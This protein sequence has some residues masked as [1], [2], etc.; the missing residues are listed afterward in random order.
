[1]RCRH[2]TINA[3][4]N[5]IVAGVAWYREDD[6]SGAILLGKGSSEALREGLKAITY[7]PE[8]NW[9][10]RDQ[11]YL[12]AGET[13]FSTLEILVDAVNDAPSM[14]MDDDSRITWQM[15]VTDTIED[16]DYNFPGP[17]NVYDADCDFKTNADEKC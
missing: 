6:E 4:E 5:I 10:G 11:L 15:T 14:T 2:G 12:S 3:K 17:I 8:P 9:S 1:M 13:V 7:Q 16:S